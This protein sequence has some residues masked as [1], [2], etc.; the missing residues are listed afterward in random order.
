PSDLTSELRRREL[1]LGMT[2]YLEA[3]LGTTPGT[4]VLEDLHWAEEPLLALLEELL[5]HL[6][7]PLLLVCLAR[8]DLL[9]RRPNWGSGRTNAI[10]ITLEP[11]DREETERLARKLLGDRAD[12]RVREIVTQIG[13]ASCRERV[14]S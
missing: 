5:E 9:V 11:L 8:T 1:A 3:R 4:I 2:R 14:V 7:A 13:R 10:A 6:R 12:E